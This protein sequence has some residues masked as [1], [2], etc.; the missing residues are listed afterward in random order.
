MSNTGNM[1][2]APTTRPLFLSWL[3]PCQCEDDIVNKDPNVFMKRV[4]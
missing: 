2:T 1:I 3:R 4:G